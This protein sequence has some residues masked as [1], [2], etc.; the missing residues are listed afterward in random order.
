MPAGAI[1]D[2][3]L[4]DTHYHHERVGDDVRRAWE[5]EFDRVLDEVAPLAGAHELLVALDERGHEVMLAGSSIQKH[6]TYDASKPDPDLVRVALD[7]VHDE[8]VVM[9]GDTPWTSRLRSAPAC[10]PS[11]R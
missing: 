3:T 1:L 11:A 6:S 8:R 4:V 2:R 5:E 10:P 7:T 9:V